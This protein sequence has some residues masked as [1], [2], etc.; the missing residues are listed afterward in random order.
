MEPRTAFLIDLI[1]VSAFTLATMLAIIFGRPI[2]GG[3]STMAILCLAWFALA[4]AFSLLHTV[5]EMAGWNAVIPFAAMGVC[6]VGA[7]IFGAFAVVAV[8]L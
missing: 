5:F 2:I 8:A 1:G 6:A 3:P 7:L 4:F